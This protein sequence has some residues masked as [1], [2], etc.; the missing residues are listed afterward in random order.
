MSGDSPTTVCVHG[1]VYVTDDQHPDGDPIAF[2]DV[3]DL[4]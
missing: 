4:D 3:S 2:L 1:T